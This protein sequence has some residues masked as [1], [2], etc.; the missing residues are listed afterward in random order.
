MG[1]EEFKG[2]KA[3]HAKQPKEPLIEMKSKLR[4]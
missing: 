3:K 2:C 4:L 1:N